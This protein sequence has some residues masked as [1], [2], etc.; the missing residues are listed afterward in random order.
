LYSVFF[1]A[2]F[3]CC[4]GFWHIHLPSV[5]GGSAN[6][7]GAGGDAVRFY[8]DTVLDR[9]NGV[10]AENEIQRR[11]QFVMIFLGFS[12]YTDASIT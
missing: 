6:H 7:V 5:K 9:G 10:A 2:C 4:L 3:F 1:W 8:R 12:R 11:W